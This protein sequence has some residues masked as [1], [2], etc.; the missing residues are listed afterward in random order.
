MI[1]SASIPVGFPPTMINV[2]VD[3]KQYQEMHVDGGVVAQVFAYP[4]GIHV[5]EEAAAAGFTRERRLYVIRNA[6]QDA[7][8]AQ[9]ERKT[10]SIAG[11]AVASLIHAQGI[12]D[13]YRIYAT[14]QRVHPVHLRFPPQGR[15][16][17]RVHAQAVRRGLQLRGEGRAVGQGAARIRAS[18]GCREIAVGF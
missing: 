7:D 18:V 16:R 14:A 2:E 10:L 17:Q 13:L 12:G 5:K 4:I 11:R 6:R 15:V 9:V 3:G 1:A 8:W